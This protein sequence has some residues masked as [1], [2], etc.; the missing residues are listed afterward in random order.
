M[1]DLPNTIKINEL[2][3]ASK[4]NDDDIFIVEDGN[5]T[6]KITGSTLIQCIRDNV[7]VSGY[8]VHQSSINETNGIAPLDG[9]KQIPIANIPVGTVTNTVFDGGRGKAL[10]DS[11][12]A[13]LQDADAHGLVTAI[14][15]VKTEA[16][17][18][19]DEKIAELINGA[20]TTLDTLKEIADAMTESEDV[21]NALNDAIG[22][23]AEQSDLTLHTNDTA[24]HVTQ[25][26]KNLWNNVASGGT[27]ISSLTD[28][29]V[30]ASADELNYMSGATSNIQTQLD[31]KAASSHGTHVSYSSTVPVMDGTASVGSASTVARSD[32]RHPIDTSRAAATH[33]H[34][35][36]TDI[37]GALP[38]VNGGTGATSASA[39]RTALGVAYGTGA[40][41]VC[42]GNDSRL[43]DARTPTAHNQSANTITAGTFAATGIVAA[44]G[45]DY[46]T[47][48]IRNNVLVTADPGAGVSTTYANGSVISVYE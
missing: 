10:E 6:Y 14:N 48:R 19:A 3:E 11:W 21:V 40:G 24:V 36:S 34:V 23:K 32:H 38:I 4:I 44:T 7:N 43:S 2:P 12:D 28:L 22:S 26:E 35:A 37:T 16:E 8:F 27:G 31:E 42:Q 15:K 30:T 29:G 17:T 46:T 47:N 45:T 1:A 9:S 25:A 13:H 39:A 5:H 20:P 41:T 18:Y 33:T